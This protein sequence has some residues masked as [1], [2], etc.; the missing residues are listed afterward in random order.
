MV[1]SAGATSALAGYT[2]PGQDYARSGRDVYPGLGDNRPNSNQTMYNPS[3]ASAAQYE[4]APAQSV[5]APQMNRMPSAGSN[6]QTPSP[7]TS[8]WVLLRTLRSPSALFARFFLGTRRGLRTRRRQAILLTKGSARLARQVVLSK[9]N[10][11]SLFLSAVI[12][13]GSSGPTYTQLGNSG[14][15]GRAGYHQTSG[16]KMMSCFSS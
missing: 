14:A 3:G 11:S 4:A 2:H 5:D 15:A 12:I 13:G 10:T 8:G 16:M 7:T 6:K 1:V 9:V